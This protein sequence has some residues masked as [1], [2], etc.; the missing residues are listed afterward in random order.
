MMR[1]TSSEL[2]KCAIPAKMPAWTNRFLICKQCLP[3]IESK[4][5]TI[6]ES[7][8]FKCPASPAISSTNAEIPVLIVGSTSSSP[9]HRKE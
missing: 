5:A 8:T 4:D 7:W 2:C 3:E 6:I 9:V 1:S